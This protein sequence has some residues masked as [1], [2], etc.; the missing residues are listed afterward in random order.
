MFGLGF[1]EIIAILAI[2]LLFFGSGKIPEIMGSVGK[3]IKM[4]KIALK[5]PVKQDSVSV[6]DNKNRENSV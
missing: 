5:A 3:G 2:F 4:F 6:S 1:P